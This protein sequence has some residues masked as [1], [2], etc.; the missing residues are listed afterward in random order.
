MC[1]EAESTRVPVELARLCAMVATRCQKA[2]LEPTTARIWESHLN[3]HVHR[4]CTHFIRL[5]NI[6]IPDGSAILMYAMLSLHSSSSSSMVWIVKKLFDDKRYTVGLLL[7]W[8]VTVCTIFYFLGAFHMNYMHVG[9]SSET[10][11][12]GLKIDNWT[13]WSSLAVFSFFNTCIN[14]FISNS[15]A[16]WFLNS[17]Q[18]CGARK[19]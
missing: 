4:Q 5:N 19:P 16:P 2:R 8:M 10:V 1:L 11:F 13:K 7:V 3:T 9:P 6:T 15:L 17:L 18:V 14:E 12:M